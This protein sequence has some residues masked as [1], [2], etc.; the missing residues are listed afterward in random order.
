MTYVHAQ[1]SRAD[2]RACKLSGGSINDSLVIVLSPRL[3]REAG[4]FRARVDV[5]YGAGRWSMQ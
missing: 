5:K 3:R 4:T 1:V 2:M